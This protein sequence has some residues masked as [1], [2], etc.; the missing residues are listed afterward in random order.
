MYT[1]KIIFKAFL[2]GLGTYPTIVRSTI[3][4]ETHSLTIFNV[5]ASNGTLRNLA[6]NLLH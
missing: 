2:F 1:I 3:N 5:A 4:P 6:E